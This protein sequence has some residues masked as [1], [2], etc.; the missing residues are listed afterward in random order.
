VARAAPSVGP[1][2]STPPG[3]PTEP[4]TGG[5]PVRTRRSCPTGPPT[6]EDRPSLGRGVD[7]SERPPEA[8][9][10]PWGVDPERR[11]PPEGPKG[12][13]N[14]LAAC[15]SRVT[16]TRAADVVPLRC[17]AVA[18]AVLVDSEGERRLAFTW[19]SA[20]GPIA[21]FAI[22]RAATASAAR[23]QEV[24]AVV[25]VVAPTV[26]TVFVEQSVPTPLSS[27]LPPPAP[28]PTRPTPARCDPDDHANTTP[29]RGA[30]A[31][32]RT[33]GSPTLEPRS[34]CV[35]RPPERR[36]RSAAG[37]HQRSHR[38]NVG[39]R[40]AAG[41]HRRSHR[42]DPLDTRLPVPIE[43]T[44][45]SRLLRSPGQPHWL[46]TGHPSRHSAGGPTLPS[47]R[48]PVSTLGRGT[49]VDDPPSSH[50]DTPPGDPTRSLGRA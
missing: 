27:P 31:V 10:L 44:S 28:L 32:P 40:S 20:R 35:H 16:P 50:R 13:R 29:S 8:T 26:L 38:S 12:P 2:P 22:S 6:V 46:P 21:R 45:T 9:P 11:A 34:P 25:A 19:S 17:G 14:V 47:R 3:I 24:V 7:Q 42:P 18:V 1:R 36:P 4:H 30:T 33:E 39:E 49:V 43:D 5:S 15:W 37:P 48:S 41:P 23:A